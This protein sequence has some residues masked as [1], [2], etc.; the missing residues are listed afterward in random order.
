MF[1]SVSVSGHNVVHS[2]VNVAPADMSRVAVELT[3]LCM[4]PMRVFCSAL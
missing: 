1:A 2:T 3:V 4:S